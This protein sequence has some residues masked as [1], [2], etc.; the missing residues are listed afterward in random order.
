MSATTISAEAEVREFAAE[1]PTGNVSR[2][3]SL[4]E[5]GRITWE[6]ARDLFRRS[7]GTALA[8]VRA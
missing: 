5:E 1:F 8:G 7:L 3:V 4:C 6:Q 2:A